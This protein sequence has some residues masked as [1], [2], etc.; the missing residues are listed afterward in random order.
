MNEREV[1]RQEWDAKITMVPAGRTQV[2]ELVR[3]GADRDAAVRQ[4]ANQARREAAILAARFRRD[5]EAR[6]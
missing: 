3:A 6:F 1:I 4:V 5:A 2:A